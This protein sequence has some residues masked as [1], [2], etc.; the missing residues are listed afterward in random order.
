MMVVR[1]G[2][3]RSRS[4]PYSLEICV[5]GMT[6]SLP[7][8]AGI[9]CT[10]PGLTSGAT[11]PL[12]APERRQPILRSG[13]LSRTIFRSPKPGMTRRLSYALLAALVPTFPAL[14]QTVVTPGG[15]APN[16][17]V[18]LGTGSSAS[19]LAP[20][21]YAN[22]VGAAPSTTSTST[23]TSGGGSATGS[24]GGAASSGGISASQS[25]PASGTRVTSSF[26]AGS[27]GSSGSAAV[28]PPSS[29]PRWVLCPPSGTSRPAPF[30]TGTDLSC[31]P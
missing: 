18:T 11:A 25:S 28:A 6:C 3:R 22:P 24:T 23:T 4:R 21:S 16:G 7:A 9:N 12:N 29:A 15:V 26:R 27:G 10:R 14:A 1:E 8:D 19:T 13:K 20:A 31:A 30:L 2:W 17:I 5:G